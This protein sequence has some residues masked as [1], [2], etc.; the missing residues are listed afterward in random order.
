M[1]HFI[2]AT[3]GHVDHGK[4]A[5]VRALTGTDPDRL[6]EEKARGITIDLGFAFLPL[7]SSDGKKIGAGIV[8][9]PGHEDFV[10]N[11]IAGVGSIDLALLVVAS[12]DGWMPQ[13]EEHLQILEYLD[14]GHLVVALTKADLGNP[15]GITDTIHAKLQG[16]RF[17]EAVIIATSAQTGE[18]ITEL[19]TALASELAA[20]PIKP[21]A[22]RPRLFIDRAF[23]LHGIGTVITGSLVDGLIRRGQSVFVQPRKLEARVRSLQSYGHDIAVAESGMRTAINLP[24]IEIGNS[25]KSVRRGDLLTAQPYPS[26]TTLDVLIRRSDRLNQK[27]GSLKN[28]AAIDVHHGT[29]RVPAVAILA[30]TDGLRAGEQ[31]LAQL[32]LSSPLCCFLGDRLILR[33]ASQQHT[34]AGAIVLDPDARRQ[35]F[36]SAAQQKFLRVRSAAFNDLTA[37]LSSEIERAGVAIRTHLLEKSRF[38]TEQIAQSLADLERQGTIVVRAEICAMTSRWNQLRQRAVDLIETT[39]KEHP[40]HTGLDLNELRTAFR[41]GPLEAVAALVSD[42]CANGFRQ[43][44]RVVGRR[45]HQPALPAD[46]KELADEILKLLA[47]RPFDPPSTKQIAPDRKARET[48]SFL[49]QQGTVIEVAPDVVLLQTSFEKMKSVIR[50]MIVENGPATVSAFRQRLE[51]SRRVVVPLLEKLDQD[52]VTLRQGDRRGLAAN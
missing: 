36:R 51:S 2:L 20:I 16:T 18:G 42:L 32:R 29:D 17:E 1:N 13:T 37:C 30:N 22:G 8:D 52:G 11:M 25:E 33:D 3:A 21:G 43:T 46:A 41:E 26:S 27:R 15:R 19:K 49:V 50:Q 38:S 6:P 5:L 44:G 14:V 40:D 12:D 23:T 24:N 31:S 7:I 28:G 10:R 39:H 35:D 45:S 9:V 4:S 34:L 48:L 47:T